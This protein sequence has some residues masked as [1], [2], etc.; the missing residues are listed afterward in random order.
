MG[1]KTSAAWLAATAEARVTR[2]RKNPL[3][4][5]PWGRSNF[6]LWVQ[7]SSLNVVC[8]TGCCTCHP[9]PARSPDFSTRNVRSEADLFLR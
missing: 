6:R 8:E 4:P 3:E 7:P 5:P 9:D 1:I 2:K